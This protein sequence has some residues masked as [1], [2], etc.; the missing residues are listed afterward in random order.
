MKLIKICLSLCLFIVSFTTQ[1]NGQGRAQLENFLKNTTSMQAKFQQKLLDQ[2]GFLLQQ[3][4]G[5]FTLKRPGRFI[6]D[7]L[8]PYEQKIVSNG[9]KIWIYDSELEQVSV[10]KY[11]QVLTGAPIILLDQNKKLDEDFAV[12]DQGEKDNLQWVLLIPKN[13][14]NDFKEIEIGMSNN[15]LRVMQFVD[16]FEQRTT[17]EFEHLK[18]NDQLD[19]SLFIFIPPPGT[20]VV[21]D[22]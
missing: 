11:S 8:I 16:N 2:Q 14:E 7:Y 19:D 4:A 18:I 12:S 20:D 13:T 22:Y 17:I 5:D 9:K 6:W 21:G 1:A 3:S 10:K 15:E